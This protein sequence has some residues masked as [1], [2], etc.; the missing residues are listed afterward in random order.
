[1]ERFTLSCQVSVHLMKADKSV[2]KSEQSSADVTLRK[3]TQS[4]ANRRQGESSS[5]EMS[6]MY[7]K[8][9]SGP[10]IDPC[11]TPDG[12]LFQS[13][14]EPLISTRCLRLVKNPLIHL[15]RGPRIP[16]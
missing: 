2:C 16:T 3:M 14:L 7:T 12:T 15:R 4:S 8:K 5:G 10:R 6:S 11:G 1:M 13:E 9:R